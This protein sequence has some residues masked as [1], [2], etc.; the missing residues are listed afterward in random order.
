M[1]KNLSA[2][3]STPVLWTNRSRIVLIGKAWPQT[4]RVFDSANQSTKKRDKSRLADKSRDDFLIWKRLLPGSAFFEFVKQLSVNSLNFSANR[5]IYYFL[6]QKLPAERS[7]PVLLTNR[8]RI[9]L[10]GKA[11]HQ[12]VRLS[13]SV[14]QSSKSRD[15]AR[16]ADKLRDN[17]LFWERLRPDCACFELV[18]LFSI[19]SLSFSANRLIYHFL[20]QKICLLNDRPPFCGQIAR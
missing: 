5:L 16:L 20:W 18:K 14:N 4:V 9:V 13:E 3:R 2:K 6:W 8:A 10:I 19:T 17:F 12:T 11:W 1:A 15:K 7:A